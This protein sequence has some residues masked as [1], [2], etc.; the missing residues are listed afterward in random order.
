MGLWQMADYLTTLAEFIE[1][2]QVSDLPDEVIERTKLVLADSVAAIVGGAAEPEMQALTK[3]MVGE[4]G[5]GSATVIGRGLKTDPAKAAFLNGAAGTF[6]EMDEGNQYARGHPGIHVVPAV[7]ADIEAGSSNDFSD[8]LVA[9]ALGYEVGSRIGIACKI[10]MSM[11]PHGTWGTVGAAVALAKL[12]G[13][14]ASQISEIINVS[15]T[16][17]LAT[18]RKTMLEGG[19]VRNVYAG[20]SNQMGFMARD[21]VDAGFTGERDG[22]A[23]VF[24][25]VISDSFEPAEMIDDLG[26]RW[27]IA[28][29]YFKRHSCCRYN[30]GALD[31]LA[32]ISGDRD[33]LPQD[34]E[35]VEVQSY[36]LAAELSD[37]SPKNTLAAKFSLPFAIASTIVHGSSGVL[38][39]TWDAVRDDEVQSLAK[40]VTVVED[41]ALTAKM[42]A[43][44]PAKVTVQFRNGTSAVAETLTNK[45]DSEDPYNASDLEEKFIE[46]TSRLWSRDQSDAAYAA[47]VHGEGSVE[48]MFTALSAA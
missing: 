41:P 23:T 16:L 35:R 21:L 30:H 24:G 9:V 4:G 7:L 5:S 25:R 42:P 26:D 34:I 47:A 36:S 11:H 40:R 17:G 8:L 48:A 38:S 19:T 45:G 18:S 10:R 44:R 43:Y 39:F 15:S 32:K 20:I 22:L 6:L 29:N 33:L 46:L 3:R 37:Q 31:A 2:V 13:W 1:N 28:R 27:E 12:K 14:G